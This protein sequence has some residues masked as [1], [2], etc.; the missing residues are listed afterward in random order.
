MEKIDQ[1]QA[2]EDFLRWAKVVLRF[3]ILKYRRQ[4]SRDRLL[5]DERVINMI[6]DDSIED[7]QAARWRKAVFR[8]C[9]K[10]FPKEEQTLLLK[11]YQQ[12]GAL[13]KL[14]SATDRSANAIYKRLVRLRKILY[15]CISLAFVTDPNTQ[16][17]TYYINGEE[18]GRKVKVKDL[19]LQPGPATIGAY[20]LTEDGQVTYS[21]EFR[22]RIDEFALF[23]RAFSAEEIRDIYE[24]GAQPISLICRHQLKTGARPEC[25]TTEPTR[26]SRWQGST[27]RTGW[28]THANS[29]SLLVS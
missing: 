4:I 17:A 26:N 11:P 12:H 9:F 18:V 7:M 25:E 23:R 14:A 2:D 20:G 16:T 1:L 27:W 6:I 21:R 10:K 5:L 13:K 24:H 8:D 28:P 3:E 19:K 15:D 22:G 29:L